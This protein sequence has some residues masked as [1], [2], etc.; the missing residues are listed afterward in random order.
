MNKVDLVV[1]SLPVL[2]LDRVPGAP[3]ILKAAA[4]SAGYSAV[5]LDLNINF[6]TNQCNSNIELCYNLNNVFRPNEKASPEAE[7]AAEQW[8]QESINEIKSYNPTFVGLS[9]FSFYQHRATRRLAIAIR[10]QLPNVKIIVGGYGLDVAA[11]SLGTD[12]VR[13]IHLIK[14]FHKYLA[15]EQLSDYTVLHNSL[16]ELINILDTNKSSSAKKF[17]IDES[18]VVFETPIPNYIDY[19]LDS[20]VW[21]NSK[22][23]PI[24]GSYGCVRS[25]TFCDVPTQFGR[26]KYRTGK[27][28]AAEIMHLNKTY[29]INVFEFTDSLVNGSFKAFTEWL[30]IIADYNDTLPADKKIRWFGQYICRPQAHT[31][32]KIY[33]LM[34][35][36]G[37]Q[38]LVIG[39]ESGNNE[40]LQAM[41]KK[42][43]IEDFY[44]EL[45]QFEANNIETQVIMF[46]GFYNETWERFVDNL[47][48]IVR[49]QPYVIKGVINKISVSI[50]LYINDN[51]P[52]ASHTEELGIIRDNYNPLYWTKTDDS[53]ND[54][55]ERSRR[56]LIIQLLLDKLNIPLSYY[57]ID[58]IYQVHSHLKTLEHELIK[59]SE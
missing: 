32:A 52:L 12:R 36:A 55:V 30:E 27:D 53:E 38:T 10:E 4:E 22:S 37:A 23:L 5:G 33:P 20:Y 34:H 7:L 49:C 21:N 25:C 44:D 40:V 48:F 31:P 1:C 41:D 8:T 58:D 57:A 35:R 28:V 19:K 29:G 45:E 18:R 54:F 46:S 11:S 39:V 56:R 3:A 24:T 16:E 59:N 13:K 42:M 6:F 14:P 2:S 15:D 43:V 26:F 47:K 50:P 51:M 17:T 9:V